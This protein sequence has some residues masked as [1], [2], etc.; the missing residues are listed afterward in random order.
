MNL[1]LNISYFLYPKQIT[2][3]TNAQKRKFTNQK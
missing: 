2:E 3:E 1:V